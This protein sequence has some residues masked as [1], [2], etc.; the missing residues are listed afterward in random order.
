MPSFEELYS[1]TRRSLIALLRRSD[2]T[3]PELAEA[4][5]VSANAVRSHVSALES[6]GVVRSEGVRR[7]GVGKP[8]RVYRLTA[9]AEERLSRAYAPVLALLVEVLEERLDAEDL[10]E[11]LREV[12]HRIGR[13]ARRGVNG[14]PNE[15]IRR[16]RTTLEELGGAVKVRTHD[17]GVVLEGL[18][19]PLGTVVRRSPGACALAASLVEEILGTPV[20]TSCDRSGDRPRCRFETG[21]EFLAP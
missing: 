4:L 3:V 9:E 1:P 16:V 14:D 12:G 11:A 2:R 8:A 15:R 7:G 20:R 10:D 5:D 19:C 17:E 13:S 18:G 6:D 21:P